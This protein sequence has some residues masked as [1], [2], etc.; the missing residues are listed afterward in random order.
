MDLPMIGDEMDLR[1]GVA[2]HCPGVWVPMALAAQWYQNGGADLDKDMPEMAR[3]LANAAAWEVDPDTAGTLHVSEG[4]GDCDPFVLP[5]EEVFP[6][7][8][9]SRARATYATLREKAPVLM[10]ICKPGGLS[11][12]D[13][14]QPEERRV[15]SFYRGFSMGM[16]R[17]VMRINP[18][19]ASAAFVN[20]GDK[21]RGAEIASLLRP[22]SAKRF[23]LVSANASLGREYWAR[24][25]QPLAECIL[26]Q[27]PRST[28]ARFVAAPQPNRMTFEQACLRA[29]HVLSDKVHPA[30]DARVCFCSLLPAK[31]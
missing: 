28:Y 10:D 14:A 6:G 20:M 11:F 31:R 4:T 17:Q 25:V 23:A 15:S 13:K 19:Y 5:T 16:S 2:G 24:E 22:G 8:P 18:V 26:N 1:S 21:T 12:Y 7:E 30:P 3:A 9:P 27:M 29:N